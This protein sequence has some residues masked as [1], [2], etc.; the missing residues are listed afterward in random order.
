MARATIQFSGNVTHDPELRFTQGGD[1][2]ASFSVAVNERKRGANGEWVDGGA[3][4]YRCT[5]WRRLAEGVAETVQRGDRVVVV[6]T[7]AQRSYEKD[8]QTVTVFDVTVEDVGKSLL[9]AAGQAPRPRLPQASSAPAD[10]AP[11]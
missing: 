8:G 2:M 5:A 1:A 4:F 9:F 11:F 7:I 6:G 3:S 10:E